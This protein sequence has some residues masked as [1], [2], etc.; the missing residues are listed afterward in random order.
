MPQLA[1]YTNLV[2]FNISFFT[3]AKSWYV[4]IVGLLRVFRILVEFKTPVYK[5]NSNCNWNT[6]WLLTVSGVHFFGEK[7]QADETNCVKVN[8]LSSTVF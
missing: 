3:L 7:L 4:C 6:K 8:V 5:Q 1:L 2:N